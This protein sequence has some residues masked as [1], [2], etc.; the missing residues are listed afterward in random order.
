MERPL[1]P[2]LFLWSTTRAR[3]P[4]GGGFLSV[5]FSRPAGYVSGDLY[6]VAR[7]DETHVAFC[8]VDAVGHGMPAALLTMFIKRAL[9]SKEIG[10]GGYRLLPPSET[11]RRLNYALVE[12]NL[13]AATFS[14]PP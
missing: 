5:V 1:Y 12:Q 6:D 14:T 11:M 3:F 2:V 9:V 10:P 13:S 7:L 8:I 4:G